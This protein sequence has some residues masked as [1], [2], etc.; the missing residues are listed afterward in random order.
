MGLEAELCDIGL[1]WRYERL[2]H[3]LFWHFL[4]KR[5]VALNRFGDLVL[6]KCRSFRPQVM[7]TTGMAPLSERVLAKCRNLGVRCVNFSTDDPF[8]PT[9]RASWFL[10]ALPF[11]DTVFTPRMSN[12]EELRSHGCK[13]V[14]YLMFG[15]DQD[16]FFPEVPAEAESSDLFFAGNAEAE[17]AEYIAAALRSKLKVRLH[18]SSWNKY[19]GCRGVSRGQAN[20]SEL[21]RGIASC[22]IALCLVRHDNRDGH[23]MRTFEI[24]AVGAC[25]IVEDTRRAARSIC[26]IARGN[27]LGR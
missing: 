16:V 24:P 10:R 18:G 14:R 6:E 15:Y 22:R 4:G 11:Y 7:V 9:M 2:S 23:S 3:K 13:D 25:M 8:N 17:R 1:A 21:R 27:G 12:L 5:P 26:Q 20:V 19:A